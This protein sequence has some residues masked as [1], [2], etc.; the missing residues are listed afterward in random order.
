MRGKVHIAVHH[1]CCHH[2]YLRF[3]HLLRQLSWMLF[4]SW[5]LDDLWPLFSIL[6]FLS[7][8]LKPSYYLSIC[9]LSNCHHPVL[10]VRV[11]T[12]L[13]LG[14]INENQC[15]SLSPF[16]LGHCAFL[17]VFSVSSLSNFLFTPGTVLIFFLKST[18]SHLVLVCSSSALHHRFFLL[19]LVVFK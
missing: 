17:L 4:T 7:L 16:S 12:H 19:H 10:F 2:I 11:D 13:A 6:S 5:H 8:P 9:R 15:F 1:N 3:I 14:I 18:H